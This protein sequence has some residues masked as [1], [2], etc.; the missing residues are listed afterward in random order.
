MVWL[1]LE[2][3]SDEVWFVQF[4]HSG[5]YLASAS[6]DGTAIMWSLETRRAHFV[7]RDH[8]EAI[9]FLSWSPDDSLIL[10]C[11][12]DKK[13]KLW[14]TKVPLHFPFPFVVTC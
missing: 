4:S 14:D 2:G 6:K 10:T 7:F 3:H 8:E 1:T 5:K 11:G 13:V 9:S 12:R